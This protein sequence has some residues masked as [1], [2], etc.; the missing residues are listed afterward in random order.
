MQGRQ[1]RGVMCILYD[2]KI[3][4][5]LGLHHA[6]AQQRW[7]LQQL[8]C[9]LQYRRNARQACWQWIKIVCLQWQQTRLQQ[10]LAEAT[11]QS[12]C[13]EDDCQCR[14]AGFVD[15]QRQYMTVCVWL[16]GSCMARS[17]QAMVASCVEA[18]RRHMLSRAWFSVSMQF[19][20]QHS[21]ADSTGS[22]A[23]L[24][25]HLVATR[26][27]AGI[28]LRARQFQLLRRLETWRGN[29]SHAHKLADVSIQ[30]CQKRDVLRLVKDELRKSKVQISLFHSGN[31][32]LPPTTGKEDVDSHQTQ[33]V[34]SGTWAPIQIEDLS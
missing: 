31:G 13:L 4:S 26:L 12:R 32:V 34:V 23:S 20:P 6:V 3:S 18:W 27:T 25:I 22:G 9:L 19:P 33:K 21:K 8:Q 2:W 24:L 17:T 10:R 7:A 28:L 14:L 29:A 1:T 16:L 30:L 15:Q 5:E 11:Q